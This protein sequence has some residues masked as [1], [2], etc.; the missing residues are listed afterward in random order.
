MINYPG[1]LDVS[2]HYNSRG[3]LESE[4]SNGVGAGADA[5]LREITARNE[6]G[7]LVSQNLAPTGTL[8]QSVS[9]VPET[10]Q[11]ASICTTLSGE[12]GA[13]GDLQNLSRTF[14]ALSTPL[15]KLDQAQEFAQEVMERD[16]L[17]RI[18]RL[19][20]ND[21]ASGSTNSKLYGYDKVGNIT[22][23]AGSGFYSYP[24]SGDSRPYQVQSIARP[25]GSMAF[26][27][28]DYGNQTTVT[29]A[30][31]D[32]TVTYT[33]SNKPRDITKGSI[34]SQFSYGPGQRRIR[35]TTLNDA[36]ETVTR[37]Y[38][39]DTERIFTKLPN[40]TAETKTRYYIG[41][42]L[43]RTVVDSA[44]DADGDTVIDTLDNCRLQPNADQTDTDGDG[45]GNRCDADFNNDGIINLQDLALFRPHF[46]Q[47]GV[48]I[49]DLNADGAVNAADLGAFRSMLFGAPGPGALPA[50]SNRFLLADELGS[51]NAV[52]DEDGQILARY[53]YDVFGTRSSDSDNAEPDTIGFTG[54]EHLH[55][56]GLIHMGGRLY[57][58]HFGRFASVDP[59]IGSPADS[60]SYS[61]Y[62]Y[63]HNMPFSY[64]D[65]TGYAIRDY[66]YRASKGNDD[67]G[68][69]GN[70][71]WGGVSLEDLL[72]AMHDVQAPS[73]SIAASN[74]PQVG[75]IEQV[76][77]IHVLAAGASVDHHFELSSQAMNESRRL[78]AGETYLASSQWAAESGTLFVAG[79][80]ASNTY[81]S[82]PPVP[83]SQSEQSS[84]DEFTVHTIQDPPIQPVYFLEEAILGGLVGGILVRGG[85]ATFRTGSAALARQLA[86]RYGT[87]RARGKI[88]S[89]LLASDG[90]IITS[91]TVAAQL[92]GER[93]YIPVQSILETVANGARVA[94]PQGVAGRFLFSAPATRQY[95]K[96]SGHFRRSEGNLDILVNE[97]DG[98]IE[99]VSFQSL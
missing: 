58:P 86:T 91:K 23:M 26:G 78:Y 25:D 42:Y 53:R 22:A 71:Y 65:P 38:A 17:G 75:H 70:T 45:F 34:S 5:L 16:P 99:H 44:A 18:K 76:H 54:H 97:A 55:D 63:V 46:F 9:Y 68:G 39:G 90:S 89:R 7:Q 12:C 79:T 98:V 51:I 31:R 3:Y 2:L 67:D 20:E 60:Q 13:A 93:S 80:A 74:Q 62:S 28:D 29:G 47:T 10:G 35:Q 50:F 57:D 19:D 94:D 21:L 41:D 85:A 48:S 36:G 1:G 82:A 24:N 88:L 87:T 11:V 43:I 49:Y 61:A 64:I 4:T 30:G 66:R 69:G 95:L 72:R 73:V 32:R 40:G 59:I 96:R 77:G 92:A 56:V 81:P 52:V 33:F 14:D 37:L 8:R 83:R 15:R 27:Y 84:F 6:R